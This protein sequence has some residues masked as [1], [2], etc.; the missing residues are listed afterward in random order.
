MSNMLCLINS[1]DW[2]LGNNLFL[3]KKNPH[4]LLH[5]TSIPLKVQKIMQLILIAKMFY[6]FHYIYKLSYIF[7]SKPK[8]I[9]S[10]YHVTLY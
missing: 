2:N 5:D 7:E 3:V 1:C 8:N 6:A 9:Q 4:N 10:N